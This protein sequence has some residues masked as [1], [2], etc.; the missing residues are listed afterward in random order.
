VTTAYFDPQDLG[1]PQPF[2]HVVAIVPATERWRAQLAGR[3]GRVDERHA[4]EHARW[5][6]RFGSAARA[7]PAGFG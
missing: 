2:E 6:A 7:A 3:E 4:L 1:P 5:L